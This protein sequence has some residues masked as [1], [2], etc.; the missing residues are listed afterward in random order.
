MKTDGSACIYT[1]TFRKS[2]AFE[3]NTDELTPDRRERDLL[4]LSGIVQLSA[5]KIMLNIS[6][7]SGLV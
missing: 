1:T 2:S 3:A 5:T 6:E 7:D 4:L